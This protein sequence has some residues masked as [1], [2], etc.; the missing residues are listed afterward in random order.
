MS[1]AEDRK[2]DSA[3]K[4]TPE[5]RTI[6]DAA[7]HSRPR[8]H[9]LESELQEGT[10]GIDFIKDLP[11]KLEVILG[12]TTMS[13]GEIIALETDSIVQLE[14]LSGDPIDIYVEDQQLGRGEVIVLHEKI[15]IRLLEITP[16]SEDWKDS[17]PKKTEEG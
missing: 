6:I 10:A 13:L 4:A 5:T 11:L 2:S 8:V 16:S 9:G 1:D 12:E 7:A 17:Q 15:R 14:K 3:E